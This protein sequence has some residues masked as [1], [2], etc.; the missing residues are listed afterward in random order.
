MLGASSAG[1]YKWRSSKDNPKAIEDQYLIDLIRVL[2]AERFGSYGIRR[3]VRELRRQEIFVNQ[4]KIRRLMRDIGVKGKG[5]PRKYISTTDSEHFNPVAENHL[6]REF[7]QNFPNRV[8]VTDITYIW[9]G[10]GWLYLAV[11]VDLYSRAVVGWA[12]SEFVAASL[13]C[14]ALQKAL[15]RRKPQAGLM[16]HSDRGIQYTCDEYRALVNRHGLRQSMSRKGNCWDNAVAESFFRSLK[17]EA[18]KSYKLLT[19]RD[20]ELRIFKYIEDF[21]NVRRAHSS[22]GYMSPLHF[23]IAGQARTVHIKRSPYS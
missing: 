23:E 13:V 22:L 14:M 10:E 18:I 8:W 19:R 11:V 12:T 5:A 3:I 4:K 9:T 15:T 17:V 6:E 20:A 16:L 21:Y 1:Y 2:H 7:Q